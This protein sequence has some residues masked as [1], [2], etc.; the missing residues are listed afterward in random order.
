MA[1]ALVR[2][3]AIH[4]AQARPVHV[5]VHLGGGLPSMSIVG[6]PHSAVREARDRMRAA[7]THLGFGFPQVRVIVNLAPVDE[8][9]RGGRFDLPIALGLLVAMGKLP[10][11]ALRGVV[12]VGELGLGGELRAV[13]G[14]LPAALHAAGAG[15]L[16]VL[17]RAN[18]TEAALAPGARLLVG[19]TLQEICDGLRARHRGGS[20]ATGTPC[21][22]AAPRA[23]PVCRAV[24]PLGPESFEP[25]PGA[26]DMADVRGQADAR[27]AVEI[28]AAGGH[29]LLLCGPPGVGKSML[30][31]RLAGIR[32]ALGEAEALEV[33]ALASVSRAGFDAGRWRRRPFR[34]PHHTASAVALVGGG[35]PPR[36]GEISLA[37]RGLLFLDELPEFSRRTL[38]TLR[39]P[40]ESGT[41][42]VS[43]G[44]EQADFPAAFQLVAA[45]NP[46]P[47]GYFDGDAQRSAKRARTDATNAINSP[48]AANAANAAPSR[49]D[50]PT[51]RCL[52]DVIARYRGRLSGPFLERIDI[53][54]TLERERWDAD[55]PP[56]IDAPAPSP[57]SSATVGARVRAA[58]ELARDRQGVEN[59]RLDAAGLGR[60]AT[61][62]IAAGRELQEACARLGLS[63]RARARTLRVART[64]ADLDHGSDIEDIHV[65]EASRLRPSLETPSAGTG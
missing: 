9:K 58:A 60:H 37:H 52:P 8:P 32:P 20:R 26:P 41:V 15:E 48:N 2:S 16:L 51:C 7:L 35:V 53:G 65:L 44:A 21:A 42:T 19:D 40:L 23:D 50:A 10:V 34:A 27:R 59:A 17:P 47:C 24:G 6:L 22:P 63:M 62:S 64:I 57:E 36:P 12:T 54:L 25:E 30:A 14:A 18:L 1:L 46:C 33:A 3:C 39:A 13:R 28:A 55:A 61:L 45:M 43:R 49:P 56:T 38:E 11:R 31:R 4:G 5:E 29:S